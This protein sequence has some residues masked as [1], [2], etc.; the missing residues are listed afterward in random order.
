MYK[1][2]LFLSFGLA[3]SGFCSFDT[4][5][6]LREMSNKVCDNMSE[7]VSKDGNS[8][9]LCDIMKTNLEKVGY[10]VDCCNSEKHPTS[11]E[12]QERCSDYDKIRLSILGI[13]AKCLDIVFN[14]DSLE[15]YSKFMTLADLLLSKDIDK[16]SKFYKQLRT[17][18]ALSEKEFI[19]D[20]EALQQQLDGLNSSL[21]EFKFLTQR[22]SAPLIKT[23]DAKDS[24][25]TETE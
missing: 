15:Q 23:R 2:F 25:T 4:V 16:D 6:N 19:T 9:F 18:F 10:A 17:S 14:H 7:L 21:G 24:T 1:K 3:I 12:I 13:Q 22:V 5:T 11:D 20:I 8:S